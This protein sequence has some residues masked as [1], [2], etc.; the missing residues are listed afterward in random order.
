LTN[1][2]QGAFAAAPSGGATAET[3]SATITSTF[4]SSSTS[5]VDLTGLT[6]TK[7]DITNGK[8]ISS[9]T[10]IVQNDTS[11]KVKQINLLDNDVIVTGGEVEQYTA[12]TKG[13]LSG[14]AVSDADGNTLKLQGR[15]GSSGEI[16]V[17]YNADQNIPLLSCL[18]V[19]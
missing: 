11:L 16:S 10:L 8:C 12:T 5:L 6:L 1:C 4:T 15:T 18:G 2:I 9:Y 3:V 7:P 19:G 17:I 14:S 13:M